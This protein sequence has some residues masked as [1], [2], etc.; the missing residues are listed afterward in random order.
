MVIFVV[1][2]N[3][4]KYA[5]NA[6]RSKKLTIKEYL[7]KIRTYLKDSINNLKKPDRWKIQLT[8]AINLTF[9]KET[10]EERL[11]YAKSDNI[12]IMT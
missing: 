11:M 8:L 7:R 5:N 10:D 12:E 6:D 2:I 4:F 9:S 3:Y 1:T